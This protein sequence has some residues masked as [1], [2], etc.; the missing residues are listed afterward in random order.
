MSRRAE[1]VKTGSAGLFG[2]GEIEQVLRMSLGRFTVSD[3][4]VE[5][6]GSI[7]PGVVWIAPGRA[8]AE[9]LRREHPE[10]A[11]YTGV[12][13]DRLVREGPCRQTLQTIH[14]AKRVF[15]GRLMK[16]TVRRDIGGSLGARLSKNFK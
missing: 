16:L 2:G 5:I 13:L 7:L 8:R 12:E 4:A 11:I 1:A 6:A 3:L 9:D 10:A 14:E 15:G